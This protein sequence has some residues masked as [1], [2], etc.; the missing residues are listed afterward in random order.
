MEH[1]HIRGLSGWRPLARS[2]TSA[3]WEARQ[4]SLERV[5]AVEVRDATLGPDGQRRFLQAAAAVGRLSGHPGIVTTHDAGVLP[6]GRPYLVTEV[7]PGGSLERW[8]EPGRRPGE[9]QV[10]DVG[11]RVADALAAAHARGVR[12][13]EITPATILVDEYGTP[14][15]AAAGL[16]A[17]E[18]L[19]PGWE[20]T[21][22]ADPAYAPPEE[23][24]GEPASEAGDV[25]SLAATLHA[26]LTGRPSRTPPG[27][28]VPRDDR[29]LAAALGTAMSEDPAE[30][31]TAAAFRDRLA[32]VALSPAPRRARGDR[33][34][35]GAPRRPR[36][37]RDAVLALA[38]A[39]VAT[40][41][42][43]SVWLADRPDD[44]RAVPVASPTPTAS[45]S[46]AGPAGPAAAGTIQLEPSTRS[47]EP[48]QAVRIEGRHDAPAGTFLR[49][50]RWERG[51]WR[52]FP[53][54]TRTDATGSFTAHVEF[55]Q[56]GR[57]RVRVVDPASGATSEPFQLRVEEA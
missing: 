33:L 18:G 52:A 14:R 39:L 44:S 29:S 5:V 23:L 17:V 15:L 43:A 40:L 6:D 13:G 53:L 11:V 24:R 38:V 7:C 57:Y 48:F 47:A 8:L 26:L 56:P 50:E 25:Y 3:V 45:P 22:R 42:A 35:V 55:G 41:G 27:G 16:V 34:G 31:P 10:R 9:E 19:E 21:P 2:G 32:A 1:P 36:T 54:P 46:A 20:T 37:R 30:R 4:A 51:S 12:H 28:R 49:V